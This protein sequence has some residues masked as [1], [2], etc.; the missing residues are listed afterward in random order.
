MSSL[1]VPY[2][3]QN[4]SYAGGSGGP[5]M[6]AVMLSLALNLVVTG[7]FILRLSGW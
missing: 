3:D 2:F 1:G 6:T 5:M 7:A 4:R